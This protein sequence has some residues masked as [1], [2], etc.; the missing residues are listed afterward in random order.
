DPIE[1]KI[2]ELDLIKPDILYMPYELDTH[3]DHNRASQIGFAVSRHN[4]STVL[5]YLTPTSHSYYPN[6]LSVIDME[7]KKK[8]V[9]LF[10]SQMDR[11]PKFM[12]IMEAQNKYFGSLIPGDGHYAEGFCLFRKVQY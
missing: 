8:L 5:R 4:S 11:R 3:Q 10:S 7:Q 1:T 9:S 6:Y 12:E 2:S